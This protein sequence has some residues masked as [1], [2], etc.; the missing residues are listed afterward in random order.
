MQESG[1]SLS[2]R[3]LDGNG[4]ETQVTFRGATASEWGDVLKARA[5]FVKAATEGGWQPIQLRQAPQPTS[6]PATAKAPAS[7]GNGHTFHATKLSI[8][9][10][11]QGKKF[12]KLHGGSFQK[13]GVTV[14][15]EVAEQLGFDLESLQPG[16]YGCELDVVYAV[17]DEGKPQKVVGLAS[18][19]KPQPSTQP[20]ASH[21]ERGFGQND[22][23]DVPF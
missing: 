22:P 20:K 13:F 17:N 4:T 3:M 8:Q 18:G 12:G 1:F 23:E 14:W 5:A 2:F 10:S 21:Q 19:A 11:P 16:E 9:F 15:P 6:A 7:N